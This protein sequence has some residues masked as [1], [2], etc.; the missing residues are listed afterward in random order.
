MHEVLEKIKKIGIVP[1]V[2]LKD[3]KDAA[4]LA[5][6]LYKGG[7]CC[8][9][10]TFRTEAAKESIR[11][12]KKNV[13]DMLVGAGTVLTTASVDDAAAAGASFIVSPGFNPRVVSYCVEKKIPIVPGCSHASD[14]ERALEY[15]LELVKFF[16]A[17]PSG[18]L[19]MIKAL[20]APYTGIYFMPTGGINPFNVKEY[21]SYSRIAACG[22][23]WMVKEDLIQAGNFEKITEL[24]KE[25]KEMVEESREEREHKTAAECNG[26]R[27]GGKK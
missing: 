20:A 4:P 12:M 2:V 1:V 8:A 18:G 10:V 9:E 22:G 26:E 19:A 24:A 5:E 14:I 25:A 21:L 3:A 11:I 27:S 17:E 16:P 13:P 7:L 15:H 6:A 23:S